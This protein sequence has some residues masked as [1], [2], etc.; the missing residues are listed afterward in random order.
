MDALERSIGIYMFHVMYN[1]INMHVI[2]FELVRLW[3]DV[4]I[5]TIFYTLSIHLLHEIEI[6]IWFRICL[7][8]M[9]SSSII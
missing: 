7:N 4:Y 9:T 6:L 8:V 3:K 2:R 5:S 1:M